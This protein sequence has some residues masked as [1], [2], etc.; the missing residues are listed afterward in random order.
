MWGKSRLRFL[1]QQGHQWSIWPQCESYNSFSHVRLLHLNWTFYFGPLVPHRQGYLGYKPIS[2]PATWGEITLPMSPTWRHL[3]PTRAKLDKLDR[4]QSM[5][6]IP[7]IKPSSQPHTLFKLWEE[8]RIEYSDFPYQ[9]KI[10][11]TK[12]IIFITISCAH[13]P[14]YTWFNLKITSLPNKIIIHEFHYQFDKAT[15]QFMQFS[16]NHRLNV[17]GSQLVTNITMESNWV[18]K[19][20]QNTVIIIQSTLNGQTTINH[21]G[22]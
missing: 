8:W 12:T 2:F 1:G 13:H 21:N 11:I 14:S 9:L 22:F 15:T 3:V 10:I 20:P 16:L 19:I 5:T 18:P 7:T 17:H 6:P 4:Q